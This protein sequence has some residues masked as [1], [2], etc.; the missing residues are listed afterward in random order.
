MLLICS[1]VVTKSSEMCRL[2]A[3]IIFINI[4]MGMGTK[5]VEMGTAFVGMGTVSCGWGCYFITMSLF[6]PNWC[7][8]RPNL[9]FT[10]E[11]LSNW[12]DSCISCQHSATCFVTDR[13]SHA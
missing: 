4:K 7:Q 12:T 6:S 11:T 5:R 9:L 2:L 13:N 10:P 1:A 3:A 8:T